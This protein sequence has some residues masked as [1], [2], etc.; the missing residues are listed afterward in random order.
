MKLEL[1]PRKLIRINKT[2]LITLPTIWLR[3]YKLEKG[4]AVQVAI[5]DDGKLSIIP[6]ASK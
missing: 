3:Q 4:N 5:E 6:E 2:L 1:K